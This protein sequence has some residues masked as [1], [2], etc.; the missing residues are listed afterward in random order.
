MK[1]SRQLKEERSLLETEANTLIQLAKTETRSFSAEENTKIVD[2]ETRITKL[3]DEIR[4]AEA[5]EKLAARAAGAAAAAKPEDKL[6][7]DFS[8][9]ELLLQATSKTREGLY[10]EM[11]DE[12]IKEA[13]A[14]GIAINPNA[15]MVPAF[16]MER[17]N[18]GTKSKRAMSSSGTAG[19]YTIQTEVMGY[20]EA[21]RAESI[22]MRLGADFMDGL[23]GNIDMPRENAVYTP[24]WET[25]TGAA[26]ESDPTF[27]RLQLSPKRLAGYLDMSNQLLLQS[28]SSIEQRIK[29][30]IVKG[31]AQAIDKVGIK[32]GGS[33]EPT[34]IIGNSDVTVC[35]AGGATSNGTNVDG[36]APVFADAIALKTAVAKNNGLS[37]NL[38]FL[39]TPNVAGVWQ[40]AKRDAGSGL[41]TWDA[42]NSR[43]AGYQAYENSNVPSNLTK[44]S[45]TGLS[46]II[47]G[48][49]SNVIIAQW[50]G[51]EI[52]TDSYTQALTGTTRL[53]A[54]TYT[55]IGIVQPKKFAVIKDA[56]AA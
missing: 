56:I 6:A 15:I 10:R 46:A 33:Q 44:G 25:E 51:L 31:Q 30:Q 11:H 54:N 12:A 52:L 50:G 16:I 40:L 4:A 37:G 36:A 9:R 2:L 38:A 14:S 49:F 32:G 55:D 23:V 13:R 35:Y 29:M 41:F 39:T 26:N 34:G 48:D 1:T 22:L 43:V 5:S 18:F 28:S 17:S 45:G 42:D 27:T 19:G 21:L 47:F 7:E 8:F 20:I 24:A 3:D 53:V